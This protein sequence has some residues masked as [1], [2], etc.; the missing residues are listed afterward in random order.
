MCFGLL[1]F[2]VVMMV[3]LLFKMFDVPTFPKPG[4]RPAHGKAWDRRADGASCDFWGLKA[5]AGGSRVLD[6]SQDCYE[7]PVQETPETPEAPMNNQWGPFG[8]CWG[9]LELAK[10]VHVR[11]KQK[12]VQVVYT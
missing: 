2:Q 10:E 9:P 11:Q 8:G 1:A 12:E 7:R 6:S 3:C 5:E 4:Q